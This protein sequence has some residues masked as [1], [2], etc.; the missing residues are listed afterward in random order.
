MEKNRKKALMIVN[1][2]AGKQEIRAQIF[3]IIEALC[4]EGYQPTVLTTQAK[5]DCTEYAKSIAS[6]HDIVV[7]CGGDGTLNETITGLLDSGNDNVPPIGYIP[8]GTT[9]DMANNLGLPKTIKKAAS[10]VVGGEPYYHDIGRFGDIA[11]FSYIASFGAFTKVS[12]STP[13]SVKNVLGHFAYVLNGAME[14]GNIKSYHVKLS[15]GSEVIEDD[16]IYVSVTNTRSFAGLLSFPD[17][18]VSFQDGLF[19]VLLIKTPK[20]V[21][22]VSNI[23][24]NISKHNFN[25]DKHMVL[26]H[27]P[28][29]RVETEEPITWTIDGE[30][31]PEVSSVDIK[32][33]P[34]KIRIFRPQSQ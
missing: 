10:A 20:N 13:Q 24:T 31:S 7:C 9:N 15:Y 12:Y 11:Y 26:L 1:P 8:C 33:I 30:Q 29:I 23:L 22:D 18:E 19:E 6:E 21:V 4:S 32:V 27:T 17:D 3:S 2:T 16:F 5:G 25:D 28:E 34:D 14:L